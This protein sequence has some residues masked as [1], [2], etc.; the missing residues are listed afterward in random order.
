MGDRRRLLVCG[1]IAVAAHA[2]HAADEPL[3]TL[4]A[5]TGGIVSLVAAFFGGLCFTALWLRDR[6]AFLPCGA[7]AAWTLLTT[8]V[9]SGGLWT[10]TWRDGLWGGGG[11][12]TSLAF[13]VGVAA[14]AGLAIVVLLRR[15]ARR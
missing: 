1:A 7:H 13:T 12:E 15:D 4:F 5:T 9:L 3:H 14:L 8:T 11:L 2:S 6:G 10:T